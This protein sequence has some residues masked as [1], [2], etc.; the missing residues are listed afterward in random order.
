LIPI[1]FTNPALLAGRAAR[2]DRSHT[3]LEVADSVFGSPGSV[4]AFPNT[5]SRK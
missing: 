2:N 4:T 5:P 3:D 1:L